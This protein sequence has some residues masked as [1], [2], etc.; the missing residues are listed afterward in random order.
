MQPKWMTLPEI[1]L[2]R[3]LSLDQALRLVDSADCPKVFR[4]EGTVYFI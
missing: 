1:A 4:T 3:H 2:D